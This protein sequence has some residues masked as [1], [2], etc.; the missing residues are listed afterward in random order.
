MWFGVVMT[1]FV[2]IVPGDIRST[3]V[4]TFSFITKNIGGN[5]PVIVPALKVAVGG[6]RNA[7]YIVYP[8]FYLLSKKLVLVN[9]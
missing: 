9:L 4:A 1:V 5:L 8:G 2:E 3:A 6:L 7:L